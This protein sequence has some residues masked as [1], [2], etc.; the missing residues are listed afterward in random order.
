MKSAL[1]ALL[2]CLGAACAL[3]VGDYAPPVVLPDQDG[4]LTN[5]AVEY[6]KHYIALAFY[7]ADMTSGCTLEAQSVDASLE[8]LEQAG[9][10][11]YGISVQDVA[12]KQAFCEKY[13]LDQ[14]MLSD[15]EKT[16]S[17]AYG[18]L[19]D[20]GVSRRVTFIVDPAR[21]IREINTKVDVRNHA[22]QIIDS[23]LAMREEDADSAVGNLSDERLTTPL[24]IALRLPEGW[25]GSTVNEQTLS[26]SPPATGEFT[27]VLSAKALA[28]IEP[29]VTT[30]AEGIP[31]D[32]EPLLV[33][34]VDLHYGQHAVR[35]D[36]IQSQAEP[37]IYS[38]SIHWKQNELWNSLTLIGPVDRWDDIARMAAWLANSTVG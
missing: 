19:T 8:E 16:V 23:V 25:R 34:D 7:P 17:G 28:G 6:G 4:N 38:S 22:Q 2:C 15:T 27:L 31:A 3:E 13:G 5:V 29:T 32:A 9:V 35:M 24:G 18:T 12:S 36:Y 21:I 1:L 11:V 33:E 37:R 14:K 20:R 10:V 26:W 30:V